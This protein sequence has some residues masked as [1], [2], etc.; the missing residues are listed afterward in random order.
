M[1]TTYTTAPDGTTYRHDV[2]EDGSCHQTQAVQKSGVSPTFIPAQFAAN[3]AIAAAYIQG[4]SHGHGIACH[5]VPMLGT[6]YSTDANGRETTDVGRTSATCT[7][8]YATRPQT[9]DAAIPPLSARP[10]SSTLPLA[11]TR[12]T[13]RRPSH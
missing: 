12:T 4:W 10:R 8:H 7:L 3:S 6:E 13:R 5:N 9:T 1:P 2:C 11:R